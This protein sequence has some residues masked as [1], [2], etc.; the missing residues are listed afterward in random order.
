M[1]KIQRG[2]ANFIPFGGG[3]VPNTRQAFLD[4]S[5]LA[6][7]PDDISSNLTTSWSPGW[8]VGD[9]IVDMQDMMG[10]QY[11]LSAMLAC[12]QQEG[13]I[14]WVPDQEYFT[15][16]ITKRNG[17]LYV[18]LSDNKGADPLLN[19]TIWESDKGAEIATQSEAQAGTD[20][21]KMMTPLRTKQ[22]VDSRIATFAQVKAGT[23]NTT[24][25]TP[26][27][28][29]Q[30]FAPLN[31]DTWKSGQLPA[32]ARWDIAISPNGT[33]CAAG[34]TFVAPFSPVA[35]TSSDG[36]T[37][38][39][40]TLPV[41]ATRIAAAPNG[42]FCAVSASGQA[43]TS[44]N[45]GITWTK[46][47]LPGNLLWEG[48]AI[49]PNGTFCAISSGSAEGG[50]P[51]SAVAATSSDG[52]TWVQR[53]LPVVASWTN[54]AAAPNGTFCAVARLNGALATI[55]AISVDNGASWT[56]RALPAGSW[57]AVAASP[58]GTFCIVGSYAGILTST[59]N[60]STWTKRT[61]PAG[62]W[63]SVAASPSGV[64]CAVAYGSNIAA[65]SFDDGVTWV[66]RILP[67]RVAELWWGVASAPDGT[68][69][70]T[71][72]GSVAATS[73]PIF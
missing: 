67:A 66:R 43:A 56:S 44:T 24:I 39:Q 13:I 37:W 10:V 12:I 27:T 53:T 63:I 7:P 21:T 61:S 22:H 58:S 54:L 40:R 42:T 72:Q 25:V 47:T 52:I 9:G 60:G 23:D 31:Y 38:V 36:V 65:L 70:A 57:R 16:S 71:N 41:T 34:T 28:L 59:D 48:I 17:V 33:F 20:N 5:T 30:M 32:S 46:R 45:N 19:P 35:A 11:T 49:S 2:T 3:Q 18:A 4:S 64:F 51:G 73:S 50:L 26:Y 29:G 14:E 62:D 6:N 55:A 1:A 15:G 8:G 69:C 68:F